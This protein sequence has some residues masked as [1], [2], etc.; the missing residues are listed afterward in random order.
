MPSM[1]STSV[2]L[3]STAIVSATFWICSEASSPFVPDR[4][5]QRSRP[6]C[7]AFYKDELSR[8]CTEEGEHW[9]CFNGS[10]LD[11]DGKMLANISRTGCFGP[12]K[13]HQLLS[14]GPRISCRKYIKLSVLKVPPNLRDVRAFFMTKPAHQSPPYRISRQSEILWI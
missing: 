9:P 14:K 1:S 10:K 2:T 5:R 4:T 11:K 13:S 8:M 12:P 6:A 7:V 3:L